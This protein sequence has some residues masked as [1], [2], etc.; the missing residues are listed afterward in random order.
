MGGVAVGGTFVSG[1]W[2]QG[3]QKIQDEAREYYGD[4]DGYSGAENSC[5]FQYA[6]DKSDLTKKQ[7][8]KYIEDRMDRMYNR[9]G[10]IVRIGI[11]GYRLIKTTCKEETMYS[12]NHYK[13][14]FKGSPFNAYLMEESYKPGLLQKMSGRNDGTLEEMKKAANLQLRHTNYAKPVYIVTKKK[15]YICWGDYKDVKTTTRR[16]DEKTYVMPMYEFRYY[17]WAAE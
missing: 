13:D 11:K 3:I 15:V 16:T 7:L 9:D 1:D 12:A 4:R 6:G 17:G 5:C 14:L 8:E 2:R 10:E